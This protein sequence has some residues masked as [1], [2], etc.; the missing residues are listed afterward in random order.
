MPFKTLSLVLLILLTGCTT[1]Q[2]WRDGDTMYL[3]GFGAKRA[4]WADGAELERSEPVKVPDI[5]VP[6]A[7]G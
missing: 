2:A 5:V 4:K 7:G 3:K 1:T 6:G